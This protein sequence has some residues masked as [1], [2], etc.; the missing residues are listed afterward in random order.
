VENIQNI[1]VKLYNNITDTVLPISCV[2]CNKRGNIICE[3]CI[4]SIRQAERETESNIYACFDYRD[5]IIKKIIWNLKYYHH[6]SLGRRLGRILYENMIEEIADLEIYTKGS[7]ILVIPVP[8]SKSKNKTRGY[9]QA[10]IIARNFCNSSNKKIFEFRKDIVIKIKDTL[11]QARTTNRN[12]RL[13]NVKG[14]FGININK[15]K[16]LKGRT[17]I[18]IDDVTTTGGTI[19]EIMKVLKRNGVKKVVGMTVAH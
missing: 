8:I 3:N 9:N 4:Y 13:Q 11:S 2:G 17:V 1:I 5:E 19:T 12:D 16:I 15:K 10:E 14:V 6:F 7:P 18:I